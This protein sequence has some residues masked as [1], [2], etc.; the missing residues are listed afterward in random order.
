MHVAP[1]RILPV[2][3]LLLL[4][5]AL[6]ADEPENR[7]EA[8]VARRASSR[9]LVPPAPG[10]YEDENAAPRAAD[11]SLPE[12]P[13]GALSL[14][15]V[16]QLALANNPSL[17]RANARVSMAA[18]QHVQAGLYPN[19][20]VGYMASQMGMMDAEDM[21]GGYVQQEFVTGGK[22]RLDQA[23]A[24]REIE[25]SQYLAG[26]QQ[27]R[28]LSDV[29]MRFYEAL[30]AQ[31]RVEL[32]ER[33]VQIADDVLASSERML[34]GNQA[35]EN[36]VLQADVEAGQAHIL[37]D[38]ARNETSE[39]WRR[40]ASVVG[41]TDVEPAQL[42]GD[43][44]ANLPELNW[45][46]CYSHVVDQNPE[47]AAALQRA[48]RGRIGITRARRQNI[49]NVDVMVGVAEMADN[50]TFAG[51]QAGIRLPILNANQGNISKAHA[52]LLA[53]QYDIERIRLALKDQLA[54]AF[55]RYANARQQAD[56]IPGR[57]SP[58]RKNR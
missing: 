5:P 42:V 47:L 11:V 17:G 50:S 14:A 2:V 37:L 27:Q 13:A 6:L 30:A 57:L 38:N 15:D 20:I 55:R 22:L 52:E 58:A 16:E 10:Y 44:E 23:M 3:V 46:D 24:G 29:R 56:A 26:A 43:L 21:Q 51:V 7:S 33:L 34:K 32:T 4:G 36:S 1:S 8:P 25:E 40:L 19:P 53:A 41:T 54:T 12:A 31:K 35:S 49:P 28:V 18:G 9:V 45:E 48:E 39:A